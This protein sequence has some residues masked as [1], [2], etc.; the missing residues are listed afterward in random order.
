MDQQPID[1]Q[2]FRNNLH[3][4]A[5]GDFEDNINRDFAA[6][7]LAAKTT[8]KKAELII[9]IS[10][11]AEYVSDETSQIVITGESNPKPPPP[12]SNALPK[13]QKTNATTKTAEIEDSKHAKRPTKPQNHHRKERS[14][15]FSVRPWLTNLLYGPDLLTDVYFRIHQT[16]RAKP[17]QHCI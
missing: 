16:T 2:L 17:C 12:A 8:G 7:I 3:T 6:C 15:L 11:A 9:K 10:I 14:K 1:S 4:I 5:Y 13:K